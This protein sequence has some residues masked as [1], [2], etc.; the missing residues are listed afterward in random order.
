MNNPRTLC[1]QK[2][3]TRG[4]DPEQGLRGILQS[5]SGWESSGPSEASSEFWDE[6][7]WSR[8]S[9]AGFGCWG[10]L[11]PQRLWAK[12]PMADTV[13]NRRDCVSHRRDPI[14]QQ[15]LPPS[16]LSPGCHTGHTCVPPAVAL[17]S[18]PRGPSAPRGPGKPCSPPWPRLPAGPLAPCAPRGPWQE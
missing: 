13:F 14:N 2:L 7:V 8:Q 18:G 15:C 4:A 16:G 10:H 17:T 6:E 11:Q 9:K 5:C 1:S 12:L 3:L